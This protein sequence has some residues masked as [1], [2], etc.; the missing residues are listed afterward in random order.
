MSSTHFT[1]HI[2][3]GGY[4]LLVKPGETV[5]AAALR[6]GYYF[7]HS[8]RSAICGTC[9]GV[10]IEG[11]VTYGDEPVFALSDEERENG[12]ALFCLAQP[13][14]DCVIHVEGVIGPQQLPVQKMTCR[15]LKCKELSGNVFQVFLKQPQEEPLRYLAGQYLEIL[16]K[17]M[18]PRPFSIANAP[19][20]TNYIE[21][22]I[23]HAEDNPFT[24]QVLA[25]IAEKKE[26]RIAGPYGNCVYQRVPNY[27][28]ILLAGG[29]GF[30]PFKAILE[31]AFA[32]GLSRD[33]YLYWGA[34]SVADLYM[35]TMLKRW[36]K[37]IPF[38]Y[39]TPVL[40]NKSLDP[41]WK[42]KIGLVH[43]MVLKDHPQLNHFHVY[44]S[45]PPEMVYAAQRSF[46]ER[47]LDKAYLYSDL[48]DYQ[49]KELE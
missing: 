49:A 20:N 17:D 38:F 34:R 1:I 40:S 25:D 4:T 9:K 23:K 15:V 11:R 10:L 35:N 6:E 3:P 33:I 30:A 29:T 27:P 16:H 8:C 42:G 13:L 7:P 5:L 41:K 12:Y 22:H 44:A 47:G 26:L 24:K 39:Y 45:G 21:L 18:S 48:F 19:L 37:E 31:Q 2:Q 14:T 32:E 43:E 36:T 46:L 28:I